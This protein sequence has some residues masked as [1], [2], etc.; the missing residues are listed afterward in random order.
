MD[1]LV[2]PFWD[3]FEQDFKISIDSLIKNTVLKDKLIFVT[4]ERNQ[5]GVINQIKR[6]V[7]KG[8]GIHF[9]S[10]EKAKKQIKGPVLVIRTGILFYAFWQGK[11]EK[12]LDELGENFNYVPSFVNVLG[13][14]LS[15]LDKMYP[16]NLLFDLDYNR[17]PI[18]RRNIEYFNRMC[19][20]QWK[21][22]KTPDGLIMLYTSAK[23]EDKPTV[24]VLSCA[25]AKLKR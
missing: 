14:Q 5:P 15:I 21:E 9:D 18:N 8:L 13:E 6:Y 1:I 25:L 23:M 2:Q 7:D 11:L 20:L 12:A 10:L 17:V 24:C 19:A 3:V 4:E 16:D 22:I